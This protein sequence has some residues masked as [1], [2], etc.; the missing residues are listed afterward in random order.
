VNH[1]LVI[2]VAGLF[3]QFADGALGMGYGVTSTTMLLAAGLTP[4]AASASVHLAQ[5]GTTLAS[6]V[7]HHRFGNVD[8]A[9][10]R[11]LA[12]PGAAGAFTG[13]L[14]L[15]R[16]SAEAARPWMAVFLAGLGVY[17]LIRFARPV[18]RSARVRVPAGGLSR[19]ATGGLGLVAGFLDAAGGGGWGPIG[20][21]TLLAS[22]Q[23]DPRKVVG[24]IDTSE[25]VVT[26]AASL[27]FLVALSGRGIPAGAVLAL[28]AGGVVAAP[29]AAWVV[30]KLPPRVLGSAIGLSVLL[31]NGIILQRS[32]GIG[33]PVLLTLGTLVLLVWGGA[34][35][36]ARRREQVPAAALGDPR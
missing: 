27:G 11:R 23:V 16:L 36:L 6:G 17:L 21:P 7:A 31:S 32:F 9:L 4:A 15:S 19:P 2:A 30:R 10:V 3:A 25:F 20:T 14:V 24:S 22:G 35:L 28:L 29:L 34:W 5:V 8:W 26:V 18:P 12:L 13:A 1:L 33:P